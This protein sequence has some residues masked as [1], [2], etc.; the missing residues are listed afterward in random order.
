MEPSDVSIDD[1]GMARYNIDA[2]PD[3]AE[4]DLLSGLATVE[5]VNMDELPSLY[6]TVDHLVEA[7]YDEPPVASAQ[8]EL[9]FSYAGYRV[10][11]D[12]RGN[13]RLVPVKDSLGAAAGAD[14]DGE[15]DEAADAERE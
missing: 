13:V 10:H 1:D 5:G 4:F 7:L 6:G 3:G 11:L 15:A 8:V 14:K 2:A 9:S 12:Q